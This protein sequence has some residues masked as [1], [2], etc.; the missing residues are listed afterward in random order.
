MKICSENGFAEIYLWHVHT[1]T[2]VFHPHN[3]KISSTAKYGWADE[4]GEEEKKDEDN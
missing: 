1:L 3:P 4:E 2:S